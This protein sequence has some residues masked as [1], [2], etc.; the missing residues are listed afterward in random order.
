MTGASVPP[1]NRFSSAT[2]PI[3]RGGQQVRWNG[4]F[5]SPPAKYM[6]TSHIG[7][8]EARFL[9]WEGHFADGLGL[10]MSAVVMRHACRTSKRA[11]QPKTL[12]TTAHK[13]RG[14]YFA[15]STQIFVVS[16]SFK[17]FTTS[18]SVDLRFFRIAM[19]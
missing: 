3:R 4:G 6:F 11:Y 5:L 16:E 10:N 14:I 13:R 19:I 17:P 8:S 1:I 2:G 15:V 18:V 9:V 7:W 12:E